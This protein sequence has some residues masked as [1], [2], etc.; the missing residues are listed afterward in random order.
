MIQALGFEL[1]GEQFVPG[2]E[3]FRLRGPI[4]SNLHLY[5]SGHPEVDVMLHFRD[6]LRRD[7]AARTRYENAKK[8]IL[9]QQTEFERRNPWFSEYTVKKA[10]EV[11]RLLKESGFQRLRILR[12][13]CDAELALV[14][15]FLDLPQTCLRK[16]SG[17]HKGLQANY[18]LLL[19]GVDPVGAAMIVEDGKNK[20][21][22]A[23]QSSGSDE[24]EL[25]EQF[26]FLIQR[27]VKRLQ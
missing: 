11:K 7:P 8:E 27:W 15:T 4:Q 24:K 13:V 12:P 18:L 3:G 22:I 19:R 20:P 6:L 14:E 17:G 1:Q 21:R 16:S 9:S 26:S 5:E 23:I 10:A 2:R 25:L